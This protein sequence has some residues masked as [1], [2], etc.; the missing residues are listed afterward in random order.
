MKLSSKLIS[1]IRIGSLIAIIVATIVLVVTALPT[2]AGG[3]LADTRLLVHMM[4]SGV[5]VALLPVYA[6]ARLMPSSRGTLDT[7]AQRTAL[8]CLLLFGLLTTATMFVCMLPIASTHTME[9]LIALHG[10]SGY[11]LAVAT[12]WVGIMS[13]GGRRRL[14][15]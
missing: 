1:L 3:H 9:T 14:P 11:A 6:I 7:S 4:A 10:W 2:L 15:L 5:V 8:R 12:V 13:L